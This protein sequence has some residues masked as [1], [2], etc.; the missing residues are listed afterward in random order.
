MEGLLEKIK[1]HVKNV[2]SYSYRNK[3]G[4]ISKFRRFKVTLANI[5][6]EGTLDKIHVWYVELERLLGISKE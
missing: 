3:K 6:M 2:P 5:L 4:K 1:E